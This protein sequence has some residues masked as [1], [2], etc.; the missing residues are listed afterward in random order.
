MVFVHVLFLYWGGA[1]VVELWTPGLVRQ[2]R[3]VLVNIRVYGWVG[4]FVRIL[5]SIQHARHV[6]EEL[7]RSTMP[8]IRSPGVVNSVSWWALCI[9]R[10][11][12]EGSGRASCGLL[13][14]EC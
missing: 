7:W 8:H 9:V 11:L 2:Q 13:S 12:R 3:V 4:S 6:V 1:A 10:L 14:Y 5:R